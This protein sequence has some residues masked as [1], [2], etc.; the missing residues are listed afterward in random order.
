MIAD[1]TVTIKANPS[2]A[3]IREYIEEI[4]VDHP[5]LAPYEMARHDIVNAYQDDLI[6]IYNRPSGDGINGTRL[7]WMP[8]I[9][10]AALNQYQA[11]DWQWTDADSPQD[12]LVLQLHL[13]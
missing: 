5:C 3:G 1:N 4:L 13:T 12:A 2:L 11:G 7:L 10:R 8:K 6:E 9:G